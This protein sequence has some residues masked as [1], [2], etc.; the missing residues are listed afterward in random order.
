[1]NNQSQETRQL[2]RLKYREKFIIPRT[3]DVCLVL[4]R[5]DASRIEIFNQTKQKKAMFKGNFFIIPAT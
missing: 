2:I 5:Y 1:M 4:N 3:G